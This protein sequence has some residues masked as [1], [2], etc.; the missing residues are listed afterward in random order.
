MTSS[1]ARPIDQVQQPSSKPDDPDVIKES[2]RT[3][4]AQRVIKYYLIMTAVNVTLPC[5]LFFLPRPSNGL[6]LADVRD[7]ILAISAGL[8][9][10][11]GVLGFIVGY[12]FKSEESGQPTK[13]RRS[14]RKQ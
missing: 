9:S 7:L 4:I 6:Q 3:Q 2:A 10:L 5:L 13:P 14:T 1:V 8:A 11:V 12:Y